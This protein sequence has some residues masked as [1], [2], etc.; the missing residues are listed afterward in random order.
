MTKSVMTKSDQKMRIAA[1]RRNPGKASRELW[2]GLLRFNRAKAG[3]VRYSHLVISARDGKGKIVGGA[4]LQ[5][6]WEET[7]VEL[8]WLSEKMRGEGVGRDLMREAERHARKRGSVLIHLN[9]YSFQAPRFYEKLG[10]RRFG[11]MSG[12]PKGASRYF[13]AKRLKA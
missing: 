3:P 6:Y 11:A 1:E 13:Y 9:T 4:I 8:L 7:Y 5:S 2:A 12:S 10:Y